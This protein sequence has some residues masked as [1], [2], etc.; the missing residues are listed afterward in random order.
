MYYAMY[1]VS[2][3]LPQLQLCCGIQCDSHFEFTNRTIEWDL[4]VLYKLVGKH[5]V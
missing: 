3:R 2:Q 5:T 4:K 1:Y